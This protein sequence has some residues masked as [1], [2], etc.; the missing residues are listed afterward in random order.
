MTDISI[1]RY[2]PASVSKDKVHSVQPGNNDEERSRAFSDG[3]DGQESR[4]EEHAVSAV[5]S[6]E[7]LASELQLE[8]AVARLNDYVQTVQRDI[9]FGIDL[10]GTEPSVTV[11]DRKSRKLVRQFGGQETLE[12]A[13]KIDA[14]EPLCLFNA[15]V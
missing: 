9:I 10:G 13:K 2:L 14:Q 12:L 6:A 1:T 4:A 5:K 11:V 8:V 15:L 3:K 7:E